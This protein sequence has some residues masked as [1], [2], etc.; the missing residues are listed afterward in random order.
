[1]TRGRKTIKKCKHCNNEFEVLMIRV[2]S[3]KGLFCSKKCYQD[4]RS[5]HKQN[6]KQL[7]VFHQKKHKYGLE[8]DEYIS[9]FQIQNNT[10]AICG[11]SF[12]NVRPCVDHSHENGIVR[13]LLCDN[14]NRG[15]GAF[16]DSAELLMKAI[17][18][19]K[20]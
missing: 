1:M 14:C 12:N 6:E 10:C 15:L 16:K 8:K 13:G 20:K 19:I 7:A 17:N 11:I 4:Y 18:Y 3:G 2:R 5:K 9:L